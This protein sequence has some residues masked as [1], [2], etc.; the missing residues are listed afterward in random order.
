VAVTTTARLAEADP[1]WAVIVAD[2]AVSPKMMPFV[3]VAT[4]DA[5]ELHATP[6]SSA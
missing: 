6:A 4:V 1:A 5:D 3:T 2:P